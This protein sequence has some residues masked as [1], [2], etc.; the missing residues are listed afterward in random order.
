MSEVTKGSAIGSGRR[1]STTPG[2]AIQLT[3]TSTSC[4]NVFIS[5]STA[6]TNPIAIGDSAVKAA[7]DTTQQGM[8]LVP[9]NDVVYIEIDNVSKLYFD[10]ITSGDAVVFSY[11]S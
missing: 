10:V 1:A 11:T 4:K 5:A 8:L 6:N 9:G 2:T 7:A 3:T